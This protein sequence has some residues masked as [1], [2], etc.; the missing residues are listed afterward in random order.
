MDY[1]SHPTEYLYWNSNSCKF[2]NHIYSHNAAVDNFEKISAFCSLRA[3]C[4]VE[5]NAKLG[6][7]TG[8]QI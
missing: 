5:I 7:I 4:Y 3:A 2:V 1:R 6:I 8:K